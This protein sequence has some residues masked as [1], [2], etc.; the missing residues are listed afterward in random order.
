MAPHRTEAAWRAKSRQIGHV[1]P[2]LEEPLPPPLHAIR[3]ALLAAIV[4]G[5][6]VCAAA[7]S[8]V[9]LC[10]WWGLL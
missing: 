2:D 6:V 10:L 1:P 3:Q 9:N 7:A 5:G 8:V 4:T